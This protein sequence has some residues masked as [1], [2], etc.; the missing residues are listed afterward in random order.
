MKNN[1]TTKETRSIIDTY[2]TK[3]T[4]EL[5]DYFNKFCSEKERGFFPN[6]LSE[7]YIHV[8]DKIDK[9]EEL[10]QREELHF[11]CIQYIYNQRNWSGTKFKSE[12]TVKETNESV[13]ASYET[14]EKLQ[15]KMLDLAVENDFDLDDYHV[16]VSNRHDAK[17]KMVQ[18]GVD[19]MTNSQRVLY[20]KYFIEKQSMRKI[21]KEVGV[22]STAI[23][24]L[25]KEVK[26]IITSQE[27]K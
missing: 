10:I 22:S 8:I 14:N 11:Y 12:I 9:L 13:F 20:N 27:T 2:F 4:N 3:R 24:N 26:S 5:E 18:D 23:F 17:L 19:K 1:S 21:A 15:G 16:G 6:M 25:I 7:M